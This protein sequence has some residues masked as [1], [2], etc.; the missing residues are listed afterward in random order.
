VG[1]STPPASTIIVDPPV[2]PMLPPAPVVPL[3]PPLPPLPAFAE[4]PPMPPG[5]AS[6]PVIGSRRNPPHPAASAVE[7]TAKSITRR[8]RSSSIRPP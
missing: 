5:P 3:L 2:P 1:A 4:L 6:S 8:D 7:Q